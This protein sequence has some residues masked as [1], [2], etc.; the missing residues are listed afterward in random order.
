MLV[1]EESAYLRAGAVES[2]CNVNCDGVDDRDLR[3]AKTNDMV[4]LADA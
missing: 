1:V 2:G 4:A 3:R